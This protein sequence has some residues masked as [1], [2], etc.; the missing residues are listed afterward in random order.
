M[1]RTVSG[2]A[3]T[4]STSWTTR[5]DAMWRRW[6][7]T[8]NNLRGRNGPV[9]NVRKS[10]DS[11]MTWPDKKEDASA[12]HRGISS[13]HETYKIEGMGRSL[14]RKSNALFN[15]TLKRTFPSPVTAAAV[16]SKRRVNNRDKET[17]CSEEEAK[18]DFQL[19]DCC[20]PCVTMFD[21]DASDD[22]AEYLPLRVDA[23]SRVF[24]PGFFLVFC[25][26]Y[27]PNLL[28]NA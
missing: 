12:I 26:Y 1:N 25:V 27:W 19:R 23:F 20:D 8:K 28:K 22:D 10:I 21:V 11:P 5:R 9:K 24:I 15:P 3:S 18:E 13:G 4:P 17:A 6:W 2:A 14:R 16:E 7:E